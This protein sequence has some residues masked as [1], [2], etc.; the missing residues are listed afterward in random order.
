M[1]KRPGLCHGTDGNCYAFLKLHTL[2]GQARWLERA[3]AF[4]MHALQQSDALAAQFGT[5][6]P[7]LWTGDL[8]LALYLWACSRVD[9]ALPT[10]DLF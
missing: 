3:P 10:L 9:D 1:I 8:G 2:T 6:V 5:R 7:S 4:A